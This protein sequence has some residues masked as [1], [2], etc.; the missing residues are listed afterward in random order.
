MMNW[1]RL[2]AGDRFAR[3]YHEDMQEVFILVQG[4]AQVT[5]GAETAMLRQ[6]DTVVIDP[7]EI[8]QMWNPGPQDVDYLAIG[9]TSEQGGRTVVVKDE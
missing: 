6:G 7:R 3:H 4:K 8:H 2:R 1:A 9:I 5:A